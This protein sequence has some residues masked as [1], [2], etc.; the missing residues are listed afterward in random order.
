VFRLS[1]LAI[2]TLAACEKTPGDFS[3]RTAPAGESAQCV[4]DPD[5]VLLPSTLTCCTECPPAPPFEPAPEWV[6]DGM[7]VENETVCAAGRSCVPEDCA[8]VPAGCVARAACVAG[9][10][11]AVATG[12]DRPS[13]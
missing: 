5:C 11:V 7:L 13:S 12:C 8:P 10:C 9:T 3:A 4:R 1:I 2:A 6:L